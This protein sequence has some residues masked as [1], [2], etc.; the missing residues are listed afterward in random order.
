MAD[1]A[2]RAHRF[3]TLAGV[4]LEA[5]FD[6]G[7][8]TSDGGLPWLAEADRALGLCAALAACVP[9]WRRGPVRHAL[10]TLVR[11]RVYQIACGY[12]DQNDATTL[13]SDPLLKL[14]CGRL[15]LSGADLAS[16]PTLS[17]L[18]QAADRHTIE[19]IA[20]ALVALYVRERG[21]DGTPGRVVLDLDGTDDP[22]HGHQPEMA[23]HGFY[24]QHMYFP[25]LVFDGDTGQL[26]TAVLRPG[27]VHGSRFVVL[28]LRRLL[29]RLR[30]AWPDVQVE[31][32]ADSGFAVPRLYA[33]C[34]AHG[35]AY[36]IGLIPNPRLET[37]AAPLLAEARAQ[38]AA[39]G[40]AKVRL[41]GQAP[42]QAGTWPAERRVVFKAEALAKGPNTR[43]VLTTRTDA[44]M[45]VYDW[46]V[47]RGEPENWIK[48]FKNALR[49]DHLHDHR[50]W[51]NA[52]RLLLH[53]AAYWLLDTL[54][55]WLA[56]M[57]PEEAAIQLDTLRLR[58]LK[59]GGRV[60]ELPARIRLHLAGSPPGEPLWAALAAHPARS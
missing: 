39:Q 7:R 52:F 4:P 26:I 14:A 31:L 46:Y 60:R 28:V 50:F 33:W 21:R 12:E 23:Y 29:K 55:R 36:T 51:S 56:A 41:V 22:A 6:A 2:T 49:A 35:V 15:P 32:R 54:R 53:A 47:D 25:L 11:Q 58:V 38:S 19:A 34:E 3:R 43:F 44:P 57:V 24:G 45:T 27:N 8:L 13:R 5:A 17:R 10:A 9:D 59:I 18:E 37:I 16:Q 48:D 20:A 30:A 1:S 42:Y 40:G